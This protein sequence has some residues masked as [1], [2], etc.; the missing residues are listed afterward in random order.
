MKK[1]NQGIYILLLS[2]ITSPLLY[3]YIEQVVP[4]GA[5][6]SNTVEYMNVRLENGI[7]TRSA[8]DLTPPERYALQRA[9]KKHMLSDNDY[10]RRID[11]EFI[12]LILSG[13][14]DY[15]GVIAKVLNDYKNRNVEALFTGVGLSRD[16]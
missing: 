2:L 16:I 14:A 9:V 13:C 8:V 12:N 10:N 7:P 5:N 1:L 3:A 4:E 15:C 11:D 6:P